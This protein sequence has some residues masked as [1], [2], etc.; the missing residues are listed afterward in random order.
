M[1]LIIGIIAIVLSCILAFLI[2]RVWAN[3][4][5]EETS[6]SSNTEF[7]AIGPPGPNQGP[8]SAGENAGGSSGGGGSGGEG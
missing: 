6:Q 3:P 5:V 7:G 2:V 8:G 4:K 1:L